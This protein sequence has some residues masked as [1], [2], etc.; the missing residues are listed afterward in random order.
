MRGGVGDGGRVARTIPPLDGSDVASL[1][2]AQDRVSPTPDEGGLG[3]VTDPSDR[4]FAALARCTGAVS[5][6]NDGDL[7]G[8]RDETGFPVESPRDHRTRLSR[9]PAQ[10]R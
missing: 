2:R 4:R 8:R 5:V 7:L 3:W 9:L 6:S 10:G 1:F